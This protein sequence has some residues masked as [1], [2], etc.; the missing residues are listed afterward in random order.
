VLIPDTLI[1][2][3]DYQPDDIVAATELRNNGGKV[4]VIPFIDAYSSSNLIPHIK[5]S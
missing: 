3:G 2:G 4:L 1:K 5:Q